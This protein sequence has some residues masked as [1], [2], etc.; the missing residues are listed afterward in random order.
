MVR[1]EAE[2]ER[3][4]AE[5]RAQEKEQMDA[6]QAERR[7]DFAATA[8]RLDPV[9]LPQEYADSFLE[10]YF[11]TRPRE[12]G[13]EGGR[14]DPAATRSALRMETAGGEKGGCDPPRS[15]GFPHRAYIGT[16]F[17]CPHES[18]VRTTPTEVSRGARI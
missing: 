14:A 1:S 17:I 15:N 10:G 6:I 8:I 18:T 13:R 7:R 3:R 5:L 2:L 11:R 16:R 9:T 4:D 12:G